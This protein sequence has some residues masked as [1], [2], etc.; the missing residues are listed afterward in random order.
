[1]FSWKALSKF[2]GTL[3]TIVFSPG[4][5]IYRWSGIMIS[6]LIFF[7]M[8]SWIKRERGSGGRGDQAGEGC[9]VKLVAGKSDD[10]CATNLIVD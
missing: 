1:M 5:L 8:H 3:H 7:Q 9:C 2:D 6:C 4:T 10:V